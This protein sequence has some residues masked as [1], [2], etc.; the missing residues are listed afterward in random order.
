[1]LVSHRRKFIY[2]KTIKT[3]GT[4][5]EA[6]FEPFC[7]ADG[8]WTPSHYRDEQAC[9]VG[10]IGYRGMSMPADCLWWSHMPAALIR[11]RV[12]E[13]VWAAYFKFCAIRNPYEK[14]L[15]TFY[16]RKNVGTIIVDESE[17]EQ[18]QFE[19]WLETSGPPI[20]RDTYL[21]DG[22]FCLDDV[23]RYETLSED[24]ERICSRLEIPWVPSSLP[25]F[26]SGVRPDNRTAEAVYTGRSREIV[27]AAYEFEL[28]YSGYAFPS[29]GKVPRP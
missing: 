9:E 5:V 27:T 15:S 21:I 18:A 23:I 4:S 17:C 28:E 22:Q 14:A 13:S 19:S 25:R 3:A 20:D 29:G 16:W 2:T 26:K 8:E 24:L 10:I 7:M 6:Y 12:G 1:M 11:E